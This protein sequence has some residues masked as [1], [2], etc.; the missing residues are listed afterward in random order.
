MLQLQKE[1]KKPYYVQIYNYYRREIEERRMPEGMRLP[2][3]RDLAQTIGVSKMTVEKAYYQLSSEGY[4]MRRHKARYEVAS[5]GT[6]QTVA[7]AM[8]APLPEP[9][10][11]Q[12]SYDFASGDMDISSFPIDTWRRYMNHVL[13]EPA[14]LQ[15]CQD[16]Q[17]VPT[18]RQAL[19]H[20]AYEARGVHAEPDRI[21][22][23]AGTGPLLSL[24][25]QLL[26]GEYDCIGVEEPG[27]R[28]GREMFRSTGY[29]I[30]PLPM[31][32]G[33]LDLSALEASDVRLVYVS[34]SHQFPLGTIMPAGMRHRLLQWA[35]QHDGLIVEDDYDS[36]LRYYGRP[37]PALQGLDTMGQ[38]VY[39]GALSKVLPSF[40]R[41]SYM[42]LPPRLMA[43]YNERRTLFRQS[44]S[45]LEQCV[46]AQYIERG[47]LARHVRRLRKEYQER[48]Q[49]MVAFLQE[50]F[51]D[52]MLI[53]QIVSGVYCRVR[54]Y[55]R[56]TVRE[57][58]ERARHK[59]C[60]VLPI[61]S[62]YETAETD[63]ER[64]FLLSFS[65]IPVGELKEAVQALAEAWTEKEGT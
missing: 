49:L 17:G 6:P 27:F 65:K 18:L 33:L 45:V 57:L 30:V 48:G 20:Y 1:A 64:D 61:D 16:E 21:I 5:L 10:E 13:S 42:I 38:V 29:G 53:D 15:S 9:E 56:L 47:E 34:P 25:T 58:C 14:Y 54:L 37:V 32:E 43:R 31:K 41:L 22:I 60:R 26:K 50:A 63:R 3:V 59:G 39:M 8:P 40:V 46:L 23:G 12:Y 51:G 44:A 2:S 24:L 36:E 55:S 11:V 7:A 19:S 4:I 35:E 28:L 62:F 52:A